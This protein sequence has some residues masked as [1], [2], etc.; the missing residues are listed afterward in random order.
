MPRG[1]TYVDNA[2]NRRVGRVGREMGTCVIHKGDV[3]TPGMFTVPVYVDQP[4]S[5]DTCLAQVSFFE[6]DDSFFSVDILDDV[7]SIVEDLR[8]RLD[9]PS[10]GEQRTFFPFAFDACLAQVPFFIS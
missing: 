7:P 5:F 9:T 3:V 2:F 6:N 1:A 4:E 10:V 8:P